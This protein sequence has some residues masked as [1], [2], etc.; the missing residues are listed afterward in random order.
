[1]EKRK[2]RVVTTRDQKEVKCSIFKNFHFTAVQIENSTQKIGKMSFF[3]NDII[4]K[5]AL[6][7]IS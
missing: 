7:D 5:Y 2:E 1:M 3:S 6:N 4:S